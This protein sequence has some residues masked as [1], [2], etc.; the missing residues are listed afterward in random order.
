MKE[1]IKDFCIGYLY[2]ERW[3]PDFEGIRKSLELVLANLEDENILDRYGSGNGL[4]S[5]KRML[6]PVAETLF[7]KG[8][9]DVP[10]AGFSENEI[11]LTQVAET[12]E[13]TFVSY[14][15]LTKQYV[16]DLLDQ[17]QIEFVDVC[18]LL[19]EL[20]GVE[21]NNVQISHTDL[22]L[23]FKKTSAHSEG[24]N[25]WTPINPGNL[26]RF[27][28]LALSWFEM[29]LSEL[30]NILEYSSNKELLYHFLMNLRMQHMTQDYTWLMI[31]RICQLGS[32]DKI[33]EVLISLYNNNKE[34]KTFETIIKSAKSFLDSEYLQDELRDKMTVEVANKLVNCFHKIVGKEDGIENIRV[35]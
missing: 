30:V 22:M 3:W 25:Y 1:A 10:K 12:L 2:K 7:E 9:G 31:N 35:D 32:E 26:D 20:A 34:N 14:P 15:K 19:N 27:F 21:S 33:K 13:N 17:N 24:L 23:L 8:I 5:L 29:P 16:F 6:A 4:F 28:Y 11:Y 18:Q